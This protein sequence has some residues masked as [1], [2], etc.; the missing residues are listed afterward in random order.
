[1]NIRALL[2][3][4]EEPA[5]LRLRRLLEGFP[6]VRVVDE[7]AD[8]V[9]ALEKIER[10]RPDLVFLDVQMPGRSGLEVA[11]RLRP[12]RPAVVFCTAFDQY[13]V[14]AFELYALDYLLKPV[15][16]A[17]LRRCVERVRASRE[18]GG[19][20]ARDLSAAGDVQRRL[21]PSPRGVPPSIE[22]SGSCE[23]AGEVGG[24][25]FDF[26]PLDRARLGVAVADVSGKGMQAALLMAGLQGRLQSLAPEA[27]D[28]LAG[29]AVRLNRRLW[30]TTTD[31]R[32]AT[33]FYA[34]YDHRDR[35]LT[36][37]NAGHHPPML[38][39]S[40]AGPPER[41]ETGG[42]A[43]GLFPDWDFHRETVHLRGGDVILM[44]TDGAVEAVDSGGVEFGAARLAE[45]ARRRIDETAQ[46]LESRLQREVRDYRQGGPPED[47]V[48]I[49]VLRVRDGDEIPQPMEA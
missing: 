8:G 42:T 3:D 28:D 32:Y 25:Y 45:S 18:D 40:A 12:P 44:F 29:L 41:L 20:T 30:E 26:I 27:G 17:R 19:A 33:L 39:R 24:D 15:S 7:A 35:S 10:L 9:E 36:Y 43:L 4:D 34:V 49:V 47:D 23:P 1:M 31:A 13:A 14:D 6:E 48:T 37:C 2:V 22:I 21:F 46:Q 11:A 5:R 16:L 38:F